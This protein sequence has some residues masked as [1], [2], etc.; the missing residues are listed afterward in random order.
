MYVVRTVNEPLFQGDL[1]ADFPVV[2]GP[3]SELEIVYY[4][5][6]GTR[7]CTATIHK[8]AEIPDAFGSGLE[9]VVVSANK[10]LVM[11]LSHTCDIGHRELIAIAPVFPLKNISNRDQRRSVTE[12]RTNF[13]FPLPSYGN[14][15]EDSYVDFTI[16]NTVKAG[17]IS[18]ASRI[19]SLD[20]HGHSLLADNLYRY[21]CRPVLPEMS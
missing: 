2:L 7:P 16:I 21:F 15:I 19:L 12:Y 5:D 8:A 3:E 17:S 1:I 13:R 10:S 4:D 18:K 6:V 11:V 20:E 14:V 9:K